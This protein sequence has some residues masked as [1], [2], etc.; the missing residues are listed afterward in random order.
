MTER[1]A[2]TEEKMKDE[3]FT[4]GESAVVFTLSAVTIALMAVATAPVLFLVAWMRETVWNWYCASLHLPPVS[5]WTMVV[6]GVFVGTFT[7]SGPT[8]KDDLLKFKSWQ[9]SLFIIL[10]QVLAFGIIALIHVW[11]RG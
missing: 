4:L 7:S 6:A 9:N 2:T 11:Y 10:G 3:K 8:L 5:F 1:R